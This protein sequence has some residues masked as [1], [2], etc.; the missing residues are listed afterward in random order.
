MAVTLPYPTLGPGVIDAAQI[1]A[2][3]NAVLSAV[4]T[5]D[6]SDVEDGA[7]LDINKLSASYEY[8]AVKL[9]GATTGAIGTV[10][11][12]FPLYDDGKGSWTVVGSNYLLLTGGTTKPAIQLQNGYYTD[13][14]TTWNVLD[15]IT[16]ATTMGAG[17]G[18]TNH[19]TGTITLTDTSLQLNANLAGIAMFITTQGVASGTAY[20]TVHLKRQIA[21]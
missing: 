20:V 9:S 3:F 14:T 19:S 11:D 15:S 1:T 18:A 17:D 6:N 8:L 4:S 7:N 16:A 2:N 5:I 10:V 21:T 13:N 12:F